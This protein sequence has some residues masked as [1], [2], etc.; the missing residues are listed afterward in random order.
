MPTYFSLRFRLTAVMAT[1]LVTTV[2]VVYELNRR[3][4]AQILSRVELQT[5]ELT[6]AVEIG[7]Q[8]LSTTDYLDEIRAKWL[9]KEKYRNVRRILIVE[10]DGKVTD[11]TEAAD[12][13]KRIF[14]PPTGGDLSLAGD[15]IE[16]MPTP[17]HFRD[18]TQTVYIPFLAARKDG[19]RETDYVV[20]V[21]SAR[22]LADTLTRTSLNRLAATVA[23]LLGG[24]ALAGVLVWR[25]TGPL[26]RLTAAAQR[27]AD[28]DLDFRVG[29]QRRDE[30]G[31]LADTFDRM[32]DQL[33]EKQALE[34]RLNQAERAA[35]IGRLASGI[36]HEIRN[37][38]NFI[39]LTIDHIRTRLA[40]TDADRRVTFDRLT[41]SVKEE[42]VRLNALVNNVLRFGRPAR[43]AR[44]P[45]APA[46]LVEA[47]F[48]I[49][50]TQAAE[51]G[52]TLDLDDRTG[53]A[54]IPLDPD[55]MHSCLSNLAINAIQAMPEGGRVA[56]TIDRNGGGDC[57]V[58]V[59]DTGQGIPED[60]LDHIFEPYYSTKET[61]IGLGLAVTRKLIEEHDGRIAVASRVGA[62]TT[63]TI[64]LPADPPADSQPSSSTGNQSVA[65]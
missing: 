27:V 41:M 64:H 39:N 45:V 57:V 19:T 37:P 52:A 4:E 18:E 31:R 23:I 8:S 35:V 6:T 28:G 59:A 46:A 38:L 20:V 7:L 13:G 56:V 3:A 42:I 11:S 51:Q 26:G 48:Q 36:A 22:D 29:V 58:T 34:E 12:R 62:G 60:K 63:F 25:V 50:Q 21:M 53:G 17:R 65:R 30:V 5:T 16:R 24:L 33:R 44:R 15:P 40:P 9:P 10:A 49:V 32:I 2:A 55:L 47:V 61:G 14:I 1:L 43:L 54:E